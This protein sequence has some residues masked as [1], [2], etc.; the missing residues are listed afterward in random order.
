MTP[1]PA[2]TADPGQQSPAG[3]PAVQIVTPTPLPT[4]TPAKAGKA[5]YP[6][7]T[8]TLSSVNLR[9]QASVSSARI[10]SFVSG[11]S[12]A[13]RCFQVSVRLGEGS[14]S[15]VLLPPWFFRTSGE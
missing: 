1:A 4:P 5:T 13:C 2:V 14:W 8:Y 6:F 12:A 10:L 7:T 9:K 3:A 11:F 15:G